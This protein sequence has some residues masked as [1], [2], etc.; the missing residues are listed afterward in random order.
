M[1]AEIC[2][3]VRAAGRQI[4]AEETP[5][6][7]R[8]MEQ[9]KRFEREVRKICDRFV[10]E[11][12]ERGL[13]VEPEDTGYRVSSPDRKTWCAVTLEAI[14]DWRE[15]PGRL[16]E[17]LEGALV[18]EREP[19]CDGEKERPALVPHAITNDWFHAV[20][21]VKAP[22]ND[23]WWCGG[24]GRKRRRE[25]THKDLDGL[26]Q[27]DLRRELDFVVIQRDGLFRERDAQVAYIRKL[28]DAWPPGSR[29]PLTAAQ[30]ARGEKGT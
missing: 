30:I 19:E 12:E 27:E 17:R 11:A 22:A 16:V 10:A 5:A 9:A 4:A 6:F 26:S 18:W 15:Q 13:R 3:A 2:E 25:A 21:F 1:I 29:P 8:L 24:T 20:Q 28:K 14:V 23:C 7:L